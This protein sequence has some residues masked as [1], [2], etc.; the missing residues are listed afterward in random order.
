MVKK[1]SPPFFEGVSAFQPPANIFKSSADLNTT[2]VSFLK[3]DLDTALTFTEI[4]LQAEDAEKRKRNRHNAR[5]GYD[6][7]MRLLPRVTPMR[8]DAEIL[9]EKFD[10]LKANLQKLGERF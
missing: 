1:T 9:A 5:T 6:T 2:G 10:R 3:I 4:A 8:A 7:L